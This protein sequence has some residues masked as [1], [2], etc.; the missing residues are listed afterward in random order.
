MIELGASVVCFKVADSMN[1][2]F[3]SYCS[4]IKFHE[5]TYKIYLKSIEFSNN[6]QIAIYSILKY[7][8]FL[9]QKR[10]ELYK[11]RKDIFKRAEQYVREYRSKERDE[12]RLARQAKHKGNYYIPGEARLAFVMRIRGYSLQSY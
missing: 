2:I 7:L 1:C 4:I 8:I 9:F 6:A 5:K 12:I 3:V 11:K 10:A